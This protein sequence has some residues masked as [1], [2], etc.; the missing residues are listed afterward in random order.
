MR[1][2]PQG[3]AA[4]A[5]KAL[6]LEPE[7]AAAAIPK[8]IQGIST[9]DMGGITA[10]GAQLEIDQNAALA[11]QVTVTQINQLLDL[12]PLRQ[13]QQELGLPCRGGYQCP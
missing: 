12:R 13:V 7:V 8:A 2:D 6:G 5:V 1:E 4:I 11:G 10:Q 9:D 3:T